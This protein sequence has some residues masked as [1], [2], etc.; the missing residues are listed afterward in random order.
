MKGW[1]VAYAVAVCAL[2]AYALS[3][4]RAPYVKVTKVT[5]DGVEITFSLVDPPDVWVPRKVVVSRG[6]KVLVAVDVAR[7]TLVMGCGSQTL[8]VDGKRLYVSCCH[9]GCS[10]IV[11]GYGSYN[12]REGRCT[13]NVVWS[14]TSSVSLSLGALSLGR[15]PQPSTSYWSDRYLLFCEPEQQQQRPVAV[16]GAPAL[17]PQERYVLID[18]RRW[19][20]ET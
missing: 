11:T 14:R 2:L 8:W 18:L 1:R 7:V 17:K 10:A 4:S 12:V 13:Y 16:G 6:D 19:L 5:I 3:L 20:S 9:S 15:A